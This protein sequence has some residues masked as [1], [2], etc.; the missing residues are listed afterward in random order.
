MKRNYKGEIINSP[1]MLNQPE[2]GTGKCNRYGEPEINWKY[3][4]EY[5][6]DDGF[7]IRNKEDNGN[8]KIFVSLPQGTKIIRYGNEEGSYTAPI[9]TPYENLALPYVKGTI[10]Y[11]EYK[12]IADK[13]T[14]EC[15]VC[16]GRVAPGFGS[17]GGAIQYKHPIT[18]RASI[19]QRILE[20]I[21]L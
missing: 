8:Y 16:K 6:D 14:V 12:V 10:E 2:Y 1:K 7:D 19:R 5:A 21:N 3:L 15:K 17:E 20:R 13:L 9:G 11:N 18:I 4:S